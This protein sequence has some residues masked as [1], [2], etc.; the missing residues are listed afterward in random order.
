M[1]E[2]KKSLTETE[3]RTRY[4]TPAIVSA[5]WPLET[6]REEYTYF[7][8]GKIVVSGKTTRREQRKRVDYLLTI[9]DGTNTPLAV[10]EAKDNKHVPGEGMQQAIEYARA[11]DV[12]FVFT[13][14]GDSFVVHDRTGLLSDVEREIPLGAFPSPD[15]LMKLYRQWRHLDSSDSIS[16]VETPYYVDG[17]NKQP[18][19][20]QRIAINRAI[21]AIARGQKRILL[22]MATGTGKT[23][24]AAQIIWRYWKSPSSNGKQKRILFLAD[25]NILIDQTRAND[26]K[27]FGSAMTKITNRHIEKEYEI[28]LSLYQAISG[29][30]EDRDAYKQFSRDFFDLVVVDECH[31]G[32]SKEDSSWREILDYFSSAIQIGLTATPIETKEASSSEY[33]GA[34]VYT[35]SLKDGIEDG[36]LAPYRVIRIATDVDTFGFRPSDGQLDDDG[37]AI[38]DKEYTTKNFDRDIILPQRDRAVAQYVTDYL[39]H[40][41]P[42]AKTIIFAQN[43]NHAER[44]RRAIAN[45]NKDLMRVSNDRYVVRITGDDDAGKAELDNFIDPESK[46]PVVATTS[47][48]M[49]T[50]VDAQTC[51]VIVL[52]SNIESMTKFKQIIGRGT[53]VREDFGKTFFTILDFRNVTKLFADPEFDGEPVKVFEP[54]DRDEFDKSIMAIDD[55]HLNDNPLFVHDPGAVAGENATRPGYGEDCRRV[56]HTVSG[57]EVSVIGDSVHVLDANGKLITE[58]L[59]SY[60]KKNILGEFATLEEFLKSWSSAKKKYYILDEMEKNGTPISEFSNE[61]GNDTDL[62]D[63]IVSLAYNQRPMS[64][65]DRASKVRQSKFFD[66]YNGKAREVLEALLDKYETTSLRAIE[67]NDVLNIQPLTNFGTS[68]EIVNL[69]GGKAEYE[70]AVDDLTDN[71]Y[72]VEAPKMINEVWQ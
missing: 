61:F 11:L 37:Q 52:D 19:Y 7:T 59:R 49:T 14:N 46:Y 44:L 2:D 33:F 17:S 41:D 32:S 55:D 36:F 13:S 48:L 4:I 50:G 67:Q 12:P 51:K 60:T 15:K 21:E 58:N 65:H 40:T 63:V 23:F 57:Q 42:Y 69:F 29:N 39:L 31:R 9:Q 8:N 56:I 26:F 20:Y 34:P 45:L 16:V 53:R 47:E 30:S 64:R 35:Y 28:Y 62:F 5:G 10:V 68:V 27:H 24:T 38:D 70:K 43:V 3:I 1:N 66:K 72:K 18:R 25:R 6:V 71:I 22:V 54:H